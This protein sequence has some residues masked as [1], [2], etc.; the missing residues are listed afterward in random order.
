MP[1]SHYP[2]GFANG[3]SIKDI[4]F[5]IINSPNAKTFW[6][7]STIGS[8][9]NKGTDKA[10]F[11]TIDYAIGRCTAARGDII[12]VAAGYTE[13]I[14]TATQLVVD[15][16]GISIIGL[17]NGVNR[18]TL[19]FTTADSAVVN[20]TGANV[21][22]SNLGFRCNIADQDIMVDCKAA[23]ITIDNCLFREGNSQPKVMI[24]I[25]GGG[26]NVCDGVTV[27]SCEFYC[28]TAG[29]GI[30]AIELG[31]V[32]DRVKILNSI[33]HGDW[34]DA[35]IHNPTGKVL[36]NLTIGECT[37]LNAQTGDHAIE[38]VSA[39][40]GFARNLYM[41][42]DTY[43]TT[44]DPGELACFECYSISTIDKNARLNPVVE[45]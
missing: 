17:G 23:N 36:T 12:Y 35:C 9:G 1:R 28:P 24:N 41:T 40:T 37:L 7:D 43:A 39:C 18:P 32:A 19:A 45:T 42:T 11:A 25:N 22:I 15:V 38:L 29:F 44:F 26:A 8:N 33:F 4:P 6:V 16:E 21:R 27:N 10:P 20:I 2:N 3:V 13:S 31:E 14:S 34:D 5:D 30:G